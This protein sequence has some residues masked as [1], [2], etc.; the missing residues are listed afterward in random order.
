MLMIGLYFKFGR[1]WSVRNLDLILL[2]L[3]AP[4]LLLVYHGQEM[5]Q[6]V[7]TE[8]VQESP[9]PIEADT[10]D[11]AGENAEDEQPPAS[12]DAGPSG[13]IPDSSSSEEFVPEVEEFDLPETTEASPG[14][15]LSLDAL[16]NQQFVLSPET[17]I[18]GMQIE[19]FGFSWLLA[20][21]GLL[22]IRALFDATMVRRPLLEPNLSMGGLAFLGC[23]LFVFLSANVYSSVP[24]KR[25]LIIDQGVG[26]LAEREDGSVN[27]KAYGPGYPPLRSLPGIPTQASRRPAIE[28]RPETFATSQPV[29][30]AKTLSILSQLAIVLGMVFIGFR[31]FDNLRMGIGTAT[32][33]LM[34]PYTVQMSGQVDHVLPAAL[35]IW[36][37][38]SYRR[39]LLAGILLGLAGGVIYYPMF[40][41]PLWISFYW[42][43]G[44]LRFLIGMAVGFV[45]L[46]LSLV[47]FDSPE[48]AF[49]DQLRQ[50]FGLWFPVTNGL[51]GIWNPNAGGLD[52]VYRIPVLAVFVVLCVSMALWPAQK[53]LGTLLSCSAAVMIGAQFWHGF[54]GGVYLAWYVP[55]LVLTI[56][57]PNLED[58]VSLAV[59]SEGGSFFRRKGEQ[60]AT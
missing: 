33:Y 10:A 21:G 28:D 12:P 35:L 2:I 16:S 39:P 7:P 20:A 56:F 27:L 51:A 45:A 15:P 37:V 11:G 53:N 31:H 55:L 24:T 14:E 29:K 48:L 26:A 4:G 22:L 50:M 59:L 46:V 44:L 34:L 9:E 43:R 47:L 60:S 32:L 1:L 42:H 18:R 40:L 19:R 38:A 25:D 30:I 52:P 13:A 49:W 41:L 6:P 5:Q 17:E 23:L 54:G 8:A 57:R 58:R 3:L 36:A